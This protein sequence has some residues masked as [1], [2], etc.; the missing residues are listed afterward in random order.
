[1]A[2]GMRSTVGVAATPFTAGPYTWDQHLRFTGTCDIYTAPILSV[3][4]YGAANAVIDTSLSD[5]IHAC[6]NVRTATNKTTADTSCMALFVGNGNTADTIHAKMQ[7]ILSSM[8]VGYDVF[9]AYAGQFHTAVTATMDTHSGTGNVC[10][11]ACKA[12]V[13][14]SCAVGGYVEALYVALGDTDTSATTGTASSGINA[15]VIENN[16]TSC[17]AALYIVGNVNIDNF[18]EF[19]T[20]SGCVV[21]ASVGG[22]QSHKIRIE[23]AG[24][25]Y[26]IPLNTA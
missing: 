9:D 25:D 13:A 18:V 23:V 11:L 3:G 26:F 6:I 16:S 15:I 5:T 21:V 24:T 7:G 19:A 12:S 4:N 17:N 14:D 20:A 8:Q 22:S 2:I 10:G 1:M